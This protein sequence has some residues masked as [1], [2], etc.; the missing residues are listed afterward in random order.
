MPMALVSAIEGKESIGLCMS[1]MVFLFGFASLTGQVLILREILVVYH[2][3]EL[4]IALFYG[5]WLGGI[6]VGALSGAALTRSPRCTGYPLL[7][8]GTALL[9]LSVPGHILITRL[10]P[11]LFGSSPAELAPLHGVVYAVIA[12]TAIASFLTGLLFPLACQAAPNADDRLIARFFLLE[13]LGSLAAGVTFTFVLVVLLPPLVSA[14]TVACLLAI[15]AG[16]I[17]YYSG[18][19]HWSAITL[20]VLAIGILLLSPAGRTAQRWSI[21][22]RWNTLHPGLELVDRTTTPYQEI[23]IA[24]LDNQISVFGNGKIMGSF[25]DTSASDRLA[26]LIMAENPDARRVLLIGG[27]GSLVR[28]LLAYPLQSIDLVEPDPA[29]F[30]FIARHLPPD[31]KK[32]LA[33]PRVNPTFT[34]GRMFV[35]RLSTPLYDA[36]IVLV[37]DPVSA[38]WNR[39][40]S[41]EFFETAARGLT[42]HGF[43]M[44]SATAAENFWSGEIASYAGSVYRT[45]RKVFPVVLATPGDTTFFLAGASTRL[46]LDPELLGHRLGQMNVPHPNPAVFRTMVPP[47]RTHFVGEQLEDTPAM[48]N[49]DH[50]P[51]SSSLALILWARFSGTGS[52]SFIQTFRRAGALAYLIPLLVFLIARVLFRL[53][54][55]DE[56]D[57]E[58]RFH[59]LFAIVAAG[60]AAMGLQIVLIYA[61]QSLFGYVFERIALFG[62]IFMAGLVGGAWLGRALLRRLC[63]SAREI[64][65]PLVA[66]AVLCL[67]VPVGLSRLA[68]LPPWQLEIIVFG[69][70]LLSGGLTGLVFPLAAARHLSFGGHLG[71]TAG[72]ADAADHAGAAIGAL[73]AGTLMLPIL[74]I[75]KTCCLLALLLGGA[76]ALLVLEPV[77]RRLDPMLAPYL[78]HF[79]PSFPYRQLSWVLICVVV[80]A[81]LWHYLVGPSRRE[82]TVHFNADSLHAVS[83]HEDFT[84]I[85]KPF[86]H[87]RG[88][89][90]ETEQASLTLSTIP[91]AREVRGFGGPINLLVSITEDGTIRG[92]QLIESDE[93]PSYLVGIEPWLMGLAGRSI[94]GPLTNEVDALT[95]ATITCNAITR[96]LERTGQVIAGPLLGIDPQQRAPARKRDGTGVFLDSRLVVLIGLTMVFVWSFYHRSRAA[97]I[98]CLATSFAVLGLYLNAPFTAL[99]AAG[100]LA[101]EIPALDTVWRVAFLLLTIGISVLW[102]QAFCGYLCPFG[103]LQEFIAIPR[104]RRRASPG[105]ERAGRYLKFVLLA[106]LLC[107]FLITSETVWF[108][109]SPLQ[110]FFS[111]FAIHRLSDWPGDRITLPVLLLSAVVLFGSMFYFRFWCRYLC[112]AGAALAVGNRIRLLRAWSPQPIP[113]KC[114][115]GV[116]QRND[117][118]CIQCHRCLWQAPATQRARNTKRAFP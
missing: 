31:E 83:G 102:G 25:P 7:V 29:A 98:L 16:V 34:D 46:T 67:L 20:P 89:S 27:V 117:V 108:S 44:C 84:L 21:D 30:R 63:G 26:A 24:R 71:R 47:N 118:D 4:S 52:L 101:G 35:N 58:R 11:M 99:D 62:G 45:L 19:R 82:Y 61:Y 1:W 43:I 88:F 14:A 77:F 40:Y 64:A 54:W 66:L 49:T 37:P 55:G 23:E 56:K 111:Q 36:V 112:P 51:V 79:R 57:N 28:S 81:L 114:D 13:A 93:T 38:Y 18:V 5:A 103:A 39:Y 92:V 113:G 87:Y 78:R 59:A 22:K 76:A 10:A 73:L 104:L 32:A 17:G 65:A 96:T 53:R 68:D 42:P 97:R 109:F 72:G 86:P 12:G 50:Q 91:T 90:G 70:V 9:G 8:H 75:E 110:H 94:V 116:T 69:A 15:G 115:L 60:T 105:L 80:M 95:G 107:L 48:L 6:G 41:L 106:V 85:E 74:G 100:L 2:G 33:D 3:T